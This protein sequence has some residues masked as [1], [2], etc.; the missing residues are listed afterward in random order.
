MTDERIRE[1]ARNLI[2]WLRCEHKTSRGGNDYLSCDDCG[3][4]WDYRKIASGKEAAEQLLISALS[5]RDAATEQEREECATIADNKK[6]G[7]T[8]P[9]DDACE[10]IAAAIRTRVA[11]EK[12]S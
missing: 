11:K 1:R 10:D 3:F 7:G 8:S 9:Y 6:I 5:E 4:E 2:K 12:K